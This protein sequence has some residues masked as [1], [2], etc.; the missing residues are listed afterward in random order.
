MSKNTTL[1][2]LAFVFL[3]ATFAWAGDDISAKDRLKSCNPTIS[4]GAAEEILRNPE[5]LKEPLELFAPAAVL[6]QRGKKDKGIFWF[7]A[8]QLRTRYQLVFEKGDR[9]QLLSIM[10]MT[11]GAPINNYAFQNTSNF[12]RILDQV[13][14]W[15]KTTPNPYREKPRSEIAEQQIAEIYGGLRDLQAKLSA[16][17]SDIEA[18]A[19]RAAPEIERMFAAGD[20]PQCRAGQVDPANAAQEIIKEKVLV[21]AYVENNPEVIRD[22]GE[23][24]S[25]W[26][27]RVTTMGTDTMPFQY[28]MGVMSAAGKES[29][30]IVDVSRSGADVKFK[31]VCIARLRWVSRD[32]A[33]DPCIQ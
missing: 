2:S 1:I 20:N 30:A 32:T 13:L 4:L 29:H 8:A 17:Q 27:D 33:K 21:K 3:Q 22:A 18:N 16:E 25:T 7:Y 24:K 26:F 15:D 10:L 31:L 19:R 9:G 23:I 12:R 28:E 5:S 6:F 14:E 11:V